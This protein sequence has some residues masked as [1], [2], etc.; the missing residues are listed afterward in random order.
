[1][2]WIVTRCR[3]RFC[4]LALLLPAAAQAQDIT[5]C[6]SAAAY[7]PC[8]IRI[9]L[10]EADAAD[11]ADLYGGVELRA[12][13]RSP[14]GGRTKV[15]PAFWD[16][17][18]R[19]VVRFSPDFEGRW[20]F[21][22]ISN[23]PGLDRRTG[24]FQATAA[25]TPGF[26]E[27]FNTRY[28]RYPLT[29]TPHFWLGDSL[30]ELASLPWET[31]RAIADRRAEQGFTHV[32]ALVL[33]LPGSAEQGFAGPA[34]PRV[35][36]FRELDRRVAY[37]HG[38]GIVT[39]L[40]LAPSGDD[41]E[42]LFPRRRQR[43]AFVRYVCARY[44][45]Y[46][47]TWQALLAWEGHESGGALPAEIGAALA[48]HDPYDHPRSSGAGVT[49]A[50]LLE[51]GG[52]LDYVVQNHVDPALASIEYEAHPAPFVNTGVGPCG[53]ADAVRKLAWT[54]AVRGHSVASADGCATPDAAGA[55]QL[56]LLG[57]FFAQTR[58]FDL[59]PHYRVVGGAA[60]ALQRV[61]YR[62]E[63]PIGIE[64]VVY[65]EEPGLV[66][67]VLPKHEYKVSWY[68][69][70]TGAWFDQKKKF[71][72]D[73]YRARTPDDRQDWVL[74]I[75]REGKKQ[76]FNK[77]F[78]LESKA[79]RIRQIEHSPNELPFEIQLPPEGELQAG[80]PYEFNATLVKNTIAAK[81]MLWLWRGEVAGSGRGSRV[82]GTAQSGTFAVPADLAA[83]YPATLSLRV[84]GIDGAGRLFEAFRTYR[85]R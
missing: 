4:L 6:E 36:R 3:R 1:M 69:P 76:D 32:R 81:R 46:S 40:V 22:L 65:V 72:G 78:I 59:Q 35:D 11:H 13:F 56:A 14:K 27:V 53:N 8:E 24:S 51:K 10:S 85:L 30:L 63:R 44:S 39:D 23:I 52:W 28:F 33:G 42:R 20:D 84:T 80:S 75:R 58:Y 7:D 45:A 67:L 70:A 26:I 15:M 77:S 18:R 29:N 50:P 5:A 34:E 2:L 25:R 74:Y 17:G 9:E 62:A 31:F 54:A 48:R 68:D 55:G 21:R 16:G 43:D 19:F 71:K 66:E 41:L 64:Y 61:P 79:P 47:V 38:L 73:R 12:E 83:T 82:F 60:L 57:Q 49:A 37:L